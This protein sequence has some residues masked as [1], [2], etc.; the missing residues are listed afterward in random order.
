MA[1]NHHSFVLI[2]FLTTLFSAI[3]PIATVTASP[4]SS[5][6]PPQ[7]SSL[8]PS[9]SLTPPSPPQLSPPLPPQHS[10]PSPSTTPQQ[11][12]SI[13]NVLIGANPLVLPMSA[14]LFIPQDNALNSLPTIEVVAVTAPLLAKTPQWKNIDV[15]ITATTMIVATVEKH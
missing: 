13:I 8:S 10:R 15:N 9:P 7:T 5:S 3:N 4:S 6:P 1:P 12:N 2:F 11:L 14:T